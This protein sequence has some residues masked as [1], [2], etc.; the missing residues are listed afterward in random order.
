MKLEKYHESICL[1]SCISINFCSVHTLIFNVRILSII[2]MGILHEVGLLWPWALTW[3]LTDSVVL[4]RSL[5]SSRSFPYLKT[6]PLIFTT[7]ICC[8]VYEN[9]HWRIKHLFDVPM[10][11]VS[12]LSS[13]FASAL[14]C[15]PICVF[16]T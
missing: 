16:S 3:P 12:I 6:G 11:V 10:P 13:K 4:G 15:E 2:R 8:E 14:P 5:K 9:R 1:W 7:H